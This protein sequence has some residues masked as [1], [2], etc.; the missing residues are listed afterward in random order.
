MTAI[1][2]SS[3]LTRMCPPVSRPRWFALDNPD[4]RKALQNEPQLLTWAI[5]VADIQSAFRR[6][7]ATGFSTPIDIESMT[8]DA[9]RWQV[10]FARDCE[11]IDA[12]LFPLVIE[13]DVPEHPSRAMAELGCRLL[14]LDI[15]STQIDAVGSRLEALG[16]RD[17]VTTVH[18][19]DRDELMVT[20]QTPLGERRLSSL[21]ISSNAR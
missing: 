2:K 4:V 20:L 9:L 10:G 21:P 6:V 12:G 3:Q 13:W 14:R 5:N 15:V 8:R 17:V 11:L 7:T 1:L 18:Q 16:A 19:G